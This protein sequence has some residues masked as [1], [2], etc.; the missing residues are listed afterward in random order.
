M[1]IEAQKIICAEFEADFFECD[2]ELKIGIASETLGQL[3]INGLRHSPTKETSGW[4]IWCGE[5]F[6]QEPDFF[7]PLCAKHLENYLPEIDK[8]LGLPPGYRFLFDG[9]FT[10]VWFDQALLDI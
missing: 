6:S 3:P 7:K 5:E 9:S 4:Y 10:D 2:G 8:F 1:K